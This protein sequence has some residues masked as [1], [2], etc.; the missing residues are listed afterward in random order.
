MKRLIDDKDATV[1]RLG[2]VFGRVSLGDK[3]FRRCIEELY[4]P[5]PDWKDRLDPADNKTWVLC[6]VSDYSSTARECVAWVAHFE[7]DDC[8]FTSGFGRKYKYATPVDLSIKYE[9]QQ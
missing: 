6:F 7:P 1:E 9:V 4:A 5:I 3:R 2:E 8:P